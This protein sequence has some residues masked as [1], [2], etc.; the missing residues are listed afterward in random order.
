MFQVG[1]IVRIK[2]EI[3]SATRN[4]VLIIG[5]NCEYYSIHVVGNENNKGV[6]WKND[7][8]KFELVMPKGGYNR[9]KLSIC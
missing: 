9:R 1:D 2:E 7:V 6:I 8:S 5:E 3:Q 4:N